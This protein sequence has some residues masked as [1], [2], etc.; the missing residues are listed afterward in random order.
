MGLTEYRHKRN[1]RKTSEPSG[2]AAHKK[3]KV[4]RRPARS[5]KSLSFV[6]Q[7]HDASR[8]HYDFRLEFDGVL[9]SWAVPKGPSLDPSEKRLA[10]EVEDHPLDYASFEGTI[11]SGEYGAGEVIV[12]DRGTWTPEGDVAAALKSGHLKFQL[13]GEKLG[14]GWALVR[15]KAGRAKKDN[16]LLIKHRDEA[17]KP[18]AEFDV[19]TARPESV[20]TGR[21]IHDEAPPNGRKKSTTKIS[22][23]KKST[24]SRKKSRQVAAADIPGAAKAQMPAA[25]KPQLAT[26]RSET[27]TGGEWLHE[28]KFD[29]YR[30]LCRIERGAAKLVTRNQLDWTH[31]Y[32]EVADAAAALPVDSAILDGELVA[33]LPN[34]VSNFQ[35]LQNFGRKPSGGDAAAKLAYYAFD[36]LYL[37]GYDLRRLPLGQRQQRLQEIL[38]S[39]TANYLQRCEHFAGDGPTFFRQCCKLGLEGVVSKRGDRPYTSGRGDD[40][41]KSKCIAREELVIGGFTL[42]TARRREFGALL[43]GYFADK[44]FVYAGRVGTGFTAKSLQE[45]RTR[46]DDLATSACPFQSVPQKERGKNVRWVRPELVAQLEFTGWTA[47]AVLRHP[48]F[49]GIREDKPARDITRPPSLTLSE[50]RESMKTE[51]MPAKKRAASKPKETKSK[52]K[53]QSRSKSSKKSPA[54]TLAAAKPSLALPPDLAVSL[55]HP[56]RVLY[57][58]S[59]LTKLDLAGYYAQ[60]AEWMLPYVKDR[61]LSLVRCPDGQTGKCFFQKHAVPS[62]PKALRRVEVA[63]RGATVEYVCVEDVAG[64]LALVQMSVLEIHPWG[65]RRDRLEYPD[66]IIFDLDPGEDVAWTAVITAALAVQERLQDDEL[67]SFVKTSG[68]KGLHVVAPLAPRRH[69]WPDVKA[70]CRE[71]AEQMS[72][73]DPQRYVAKMTKSARG[74][75]IFIDYLRNDRGSTAIAPYSTRARIGAPIATPLAW[76]ELSKDIRADHFQV[77]NLLERLKSLP[78]DPWDGFFTLKQNLPRRKK[79][80]SRKRS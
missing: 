24:S 4:A 13:Q 50:R 21:L 44:E 63:E 11:P 71:I 23:T 29:G 65:S 40:W 66:Q 41:I 73:D 58:D 32:R 1:F 2:N 30:I 18:T 8:L 53:T 76:D 61:P 12:W 48:S 33:L 35:A 3:K 5:A 77:G 22:T 49:Q 25:I 47:D 27:P 69:D 70:Y 79:S 57:P 36:L 74:G 67:E 10:V 60:V 80:E 42:S 20:K 14:G 75:K 19:T 72:A 6:V 55:T 51:Q 45:L 7:K 78:G 17:S 54:R 52:S 39:D 34:G 31:R 15:L 68:G 16:W 43:V 56:E 28:I 62:T 26:L 46:L 64:L 9:K 38:P 37:D 59:E